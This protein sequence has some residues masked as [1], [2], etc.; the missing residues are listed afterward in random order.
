[1]ESNAVYNPKLTFNTTVLELNFL[2]TYP[3]L[4]KIQTHTNGTNN[5]LSLIFVVLA[6]WNNILW[7][8]MSL[9]SDTLSWFQSVTCGMLVVFSV[10]SGFLHQ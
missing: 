8:D 7:V 6:H 4:N 1:M 9:Y 5:T 2:L 10:Y 3:S